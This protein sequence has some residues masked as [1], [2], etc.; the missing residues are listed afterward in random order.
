MD[1][2]LARETCHASIPVAKVIRLCDLELL[3][4]ILEHVGNLNKKFEAQLLF[5]DSLGENWFWESLGG[6]GWEFFT[7]ILP[8]GEVRWKAVQ[9]N[10]GR[11]RWG[12]KCLP[13]PN[14]HLILGGWIYILSPMLALYYDSILLSTV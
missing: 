5:T 1:V 3:E 6:V 9:K 8:L 10:L 7:E 11:V 4:S 12:E 2:Q 13:S 14:L